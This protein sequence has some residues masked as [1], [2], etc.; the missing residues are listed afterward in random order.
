MLGFVSALTDLVHSFT[1]VP[2]CYQRFLQ[3]SALFLNG[4]SIDISFGKD[5][6]THRE[7]S[8]PTLEAN[9]VVHMSL[10]SIAIVSCWELLRTGR[11]VGLM[12]L[13]LSDLES[14]HSSPNKSGS[15]LETTQ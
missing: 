5:T 3:L 8:K 13:N 14:E 7:D 15:S 10:V 2:H 11:C 1:V 6:S 12:K 4:L 9:L